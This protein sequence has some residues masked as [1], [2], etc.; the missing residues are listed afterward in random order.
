[1]LHRAH[2]QHATSD[3]LGEPLNVVVSNLSD[4]FILAEAGFRD[5]LYSIQYSGEY[6]GISIGGPQTANLGDG[7]GSREYA[8][9][10]QESRP[11]RS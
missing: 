11:R 9:S 4:P 5:W 6:A 1:M 3:D 7:Q 2:L 10:R 8:M